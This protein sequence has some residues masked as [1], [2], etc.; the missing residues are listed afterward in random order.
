MNTFA[1]KVYL[2]NAVNNQRFRNV[3]KIDLTPE[4]LLKSGPK[5]HTD[6]TVVNT[7]HRW[8]TIQEVREKERRARLAR[9]REY[10][11]LLEKNGWTRAELARQLGVSRVWVTT[12]LK[13]DQ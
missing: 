4:H 13:V 3:G 5:L 9:A 10:R 11:K 8:L 2:P 12:V 7:S 1:I 6:G